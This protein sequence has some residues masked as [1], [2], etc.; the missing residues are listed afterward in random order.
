VTAPLDSLIFVPSVK[1]THGREDTV[2]F[3]SDTCDP[4]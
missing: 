1:T 4:T 2:A 3:D